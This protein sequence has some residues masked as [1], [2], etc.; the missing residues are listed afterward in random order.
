MYH[1][2]ALKKLVRGNMDE[3]CGLSDPLSGGDD[4]DISFSKAAMDRLFQDP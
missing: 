2:F 1:V 4:S 3:A